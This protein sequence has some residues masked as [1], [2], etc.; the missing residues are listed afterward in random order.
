VGLH[1]RGAGESA[2][3]NV[4]SPE[5]LS[6]TL[7]PDAHWVAYAA[8]QRS[9]AAISQNRGVFVEPYPPTGARYQ[10]PKRLLDYHPLWAPDGKSI[11]FVA[12]ANRAMMAV[13]IST[14]PTIA[15]GTPIELP[16]AP[17]PG[18]LS[19]DFRGYDALPDARLV[20]VSPWAGAAAAGVP[21]VEIR[22][23]LNWFEEL[24]RLVPAKP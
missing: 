3:R 1:D 22:V 4:T 21:T 8:K 23:V 16:H 19:I 6:A 13:P 2:V 18:M 17:V 20:A 15:F 24:K 10:A 7:S 5:P 9:R 11:F 12:G 14:R